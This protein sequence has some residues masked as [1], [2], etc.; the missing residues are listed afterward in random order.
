L[1]HPFAIGQ[2]GGAVVGA[3]VRV[4]DRVRKL[5]L[6]GVGAEAKDLVQD[7]ARHRA[8]AVTAC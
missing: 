4:A 8:E 2:V 1:H 5:V 6:D 7:G 3:A